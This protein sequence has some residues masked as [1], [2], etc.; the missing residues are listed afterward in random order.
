MVFCVSSVSPLKSLHPP[1]LLT[2]PTE[3]DKSSSLTSLVIT[4][5]R[6]R[7]HTMLL[8]LRSDGSIHAARLSKSRNGSREKQATKATQE[9]LNVIW[10]NDVERL[11]DR[12]GAEPDIGKAATRFR[13]I[14]ARWAWLG[15]HGARLLQFTQA[16][17]L[18]SGC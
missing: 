18:R 3:M 11:S 7:H 12:V 10:D 6:G 14:D 9:V 16:D 1:Y 17:C 15:K 5:S 2:V 8:G 4:P 13:I